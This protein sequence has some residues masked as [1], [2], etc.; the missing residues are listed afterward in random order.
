ML[1]YSKTKS[2]MLL[3]GLDIKYYKQKVKYTDKYAGVWSAH[4]S[5]LYHKG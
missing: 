5:P 1:W 4:V 3:K 2:L